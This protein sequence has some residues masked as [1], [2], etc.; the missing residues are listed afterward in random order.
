MAYRFRLQ[1]PIA[2]EVRR[3][4]LEQIDIAEE[5][6]ASKDDVASA[7]HDARRCLKRLRALI[8]LVRPALGDGVYRRESERVASTGR[9]LAGARDVHVM[10]LTA[11]KLESRFGPLPDG[12]GK[13]LQALLAANAASVPSGAGK[14]GRAQAL[15]HLRQTRKFFAG[16]ALDGIGIDALAEGLERC[17]RKGR[18]G[19]REAFRKPSDETFHAWRKSAQRHWRHMQLIQ[20]AWPEALSARAGEAKELSRLLG[21]DH[22]LAVL[23]L[24]VTQG[25]DAALTRDDIAAVTSLCR[26]CQAEIRAQAEPRGARLFAEPA[27][28]LRRRI[29]AYWSSAC[30]LAE[31][32]PPEERAP[33]RKTSTAERR[34]TRRRKAQA[35]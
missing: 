26:A 25:S 35:T 21:E 27:E 23:L 29:E 33:V 13:R 1:E 31:C 16:H 9:L 4:A 24:A 8:R 18:R 12:G 28:E 19:F 34:T 7:I 20:R 17:Y 5:K 14:D 30:R 2:Q 10:R 3:V 15:K 6:L 11:A 32:S 22:D